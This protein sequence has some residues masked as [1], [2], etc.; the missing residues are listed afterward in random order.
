[1]QSREPQIGDRTPGQTLEKI[2]HQVPTVEH[3]QRQQV[4]HTQADTDQSQKTQ[5]IRQTLLNRL[6]C[7]VSNGQRTAQVLQ[8][9]LANQHPAD[10]LDRQ[11]RHLPG[12]GQP[13][14][15][16]FDRTEL[17]PHQFWRRTDESV[18]AANAA[19]T[20]T[21][22][23]RGDGQLDHLCA[24]L[25]LPLHRLDHA[26]AN[27]GSNPLAQSLRIADRLTLEAQHAVTF[28][29]SSQR[30]GT[31]HLDLA[32][33][34]FAVGLAQADA[35]DQRCVHVLRTELI[36]A[37]PQLTTTA[38]LRIAELQ[39]QCLPLQQVLG[40][41]P[42]QITERAQVHPLA[43]IVLPCLHPVACAHAGALGQTARRGCTQ[44]GLGFVNSYPMRAGVQQHRQQ[45]VRQR[46]GSDDRHALPQRFA[47][48]RLVQLT[49]GHRPL[50]LVQH[51]HIAA[52]G[53]SRQHEL[54][55]FA[56][57][58]AA[59]DHTA[60]SHREPQHLD[61]AGHRH[62]VMTV[63]MHDDQHRQRQQ[64]SQHGDHLASSRAVR[65]A[66]PRARPSSASRS[67]SEPASA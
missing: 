3:R 53:Q 21:H 28:L 54:G 50:A 40:E 26:V 47:V 31:A 58:L 17:H 32:E 38:A 6:T 15:Q 52:Q 37:Q 22:Q 56:R 1:M 34:G 20:L 36:E 13:L 29:K 43:L 63:F 19:I 5:V 2:I 30:C 55:V 57:F 60:E 18:D 42:A 64:K 33:H 12:P 10:H 9:G 51:A 23:A 11:R 24:A 8:R 62:T 25:Q 67:S 41:L 65:S 39:L 7:D 45:Q 16:A 4:E 49:G 59:P 46:S 48:E 35:L 61:T 27:R 66:K 44:Q 14:G